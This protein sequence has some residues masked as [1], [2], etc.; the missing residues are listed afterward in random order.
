[1]KK[2]QKYDRRRAVN[3]KLIRKSKS[4]PG[5]CKYEVTVAEVDGTYHKEPAYGRDM[6]DAISRLLWKERTIKVEKKINSTWVALAICL[7]IG[8]PA[9]LASQENQPLYLISSLAGTILLFG[10]IFVW[11]NYLEKANE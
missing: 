6:Q 9:F 8:W 10:G 3:C 2:K 4:N 1:M 11:Y 7:S 5:Y